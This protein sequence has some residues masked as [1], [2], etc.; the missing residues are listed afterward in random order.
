[1]TSS[2]RIW[3]VRFIICV[4]VCILIGRN[5]YDYLIICKCYWCCHLISANILNCS[6]MTTTIMMM[7][8]PLRI[9]YYSIDGCV[10]NTSTTRER[11]IESYTLLNS[12]NNYRF[13]CLY[14]MIN[15]CRNVFF[16]FIS[17]FHLVH[18]FCWWS[19]VDC[20]IRHRTYAT[21]IK[22][23]W[24]KTFGVLSKKNEYLYNVVKRFNWSY[25]LQG[26]SQLKLQSMLI[27]LL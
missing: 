27:V 20:L 19:N 22:S 25:H 12:K 7:D 21:C 23:E 5:S 4:H 11:R 14:G 18:W 17:S 16:F 9:E 6:M 8:L 1:M 15:D 26:S 24:K 3:E 13:K 2:F 10:E